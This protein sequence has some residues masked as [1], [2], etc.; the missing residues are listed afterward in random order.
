MS[1][2]HSRTLSVRVHGT[3][4]GPGIIHIHQKRAHSCRLNIECYPGSDDRLSHRCL[5]I[6]PCR[7]SAL[8]PSCSLPEEWQI[9]R[10]KSI[11]KNCREI[12][13]TC[14]TFPAVLG[15]T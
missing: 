13:Q 7:L 2:L 8:K 4:G 1:K 14:G 12:Y 15:G 6:T 3:L 9:L 5:P 10:P 11:F